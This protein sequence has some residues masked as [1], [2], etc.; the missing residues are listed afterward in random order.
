MWYCPEKYKTDSPEDINKVLS[1]RKGQLEGKE[2][3]RS[4][5]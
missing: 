4:L 2:A 5:A 3:K 1:E